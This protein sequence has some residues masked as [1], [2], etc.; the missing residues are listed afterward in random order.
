MSRTNP[1]P[2]S[3]EAPSVV[4]AARTRSQASRRSETGRRL[5]PTIARW[6]LDIDG[7]ADIGPGHDSSLAIVRHC[8]TEYRSGRADVASRVWHDDIAWTVRGRPPASGVW[9]G[10][11]GVFAYHALLERLSG[12]TYRQRLMGLAGSRGSIVDAYLRTTATR[13][14]R[15]L[16]IPT[17][18]VFELVGGRVRRVTEI[19]GDQEAWDKF[20]AD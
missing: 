7:G 17:L 15:R 18:T 3:A 16:E 6:P 5:A 20:W 12:G 2:R 1:A 19:P 11:E 13:N 10:P 4:F 14:G 8:L 9:T